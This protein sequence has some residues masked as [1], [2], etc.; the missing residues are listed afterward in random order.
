MLPRVSLQRPSATL[1]PRQ[2]VLIESS[3]EGRK[4]G[5]RR[6]EASAF[7]KA[8][9]GGGADLRASGDPSASDAALAVIGG[10]ITAG[11]SDGEGSRTQIDVFT[12]N[13]NERDAEDRETFVNKH[14]T[15]ISPRL[16]EY[17]IVIKLKVFE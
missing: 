11:E 14:Q 8:R 6:T 15:G 1:T 3:R 12:P 17:S 4:A 9:G 2:R 16:F 5:E 7:I 10:D 13:S